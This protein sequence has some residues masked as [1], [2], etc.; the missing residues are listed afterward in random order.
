[1]SLSFENCTVDAKANI[2]FDGK[3][4]SHVVYFADGSSKTLGLIYAGEYHLGTDAPE[5]MDIISG[6]CKVVVDGTTETQTIVAPS[7]FNVPG[8]SGFTIT[9]ADCICEYVCTYLKE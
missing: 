2:Y 3:I 6:T 1:M 4:A 8:K 9:V 7:H 5:R